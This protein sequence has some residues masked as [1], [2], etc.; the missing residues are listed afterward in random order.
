[1]ACQINGVV[2]RMNKF[3]IRLFV[4]FCGLLLSHDL[5]AQAQS[6]NKVVITDD[7][8]ILLDVTLNGVTVTRSI[9]AYQVEDK[10]LLAIEPLFD[11]LKVRYTIKNTT[12]SIWQNDKEQEFDLRSDTKAKT[13]QNYLWASDDFYFFTE[14]ALVERLFPAKMEFL[15]KGLILKIVTP[16]EVAIFPRQKI[17]QQNRQ[18]RL[19]K[20]D[21]VATNNEIIQRPIT[22]A[23]QY[24]L[25]TVPHGRVNIA[26]ETNNTATAINGSAQL[27]A[28]LLYHSA[29]LTL[30]DSDN[31]DLAARLVLSRYKTKPDDYILGVYDQ[32]QLGDVSSTTNGISTATAGGLGLNLRRQPTNFRQ[33]NQAITLEETAPPGWEAELFRNNIFLAATTVP[34][35]GLLIFDDVE[36]EFGINKYEVRLYGPF[37]ET[38]VRTK[39]V[40]LTQNSLAKGQFSHSLYGLDR[41]YRL[42]NNQSDTGYRL[43]D[44]GGTL[45]YG[46]SDNWQVGFGYAGL[47]D[48][49]QFYNLKNALSLPSLLLENDIS[50]DQ[51]GN[52]AQLTNLK[53]RAFEEDRYS[54]VFESADDFSSN[55]VSAVGKSLGLQGEYTRVT[56][57]ANLNFSLGYREDDLSKNINVGNRLS[58]NIGKVRVRHNLFYFENTFFQ[59]GQNTMNSGLQGALA[60]SGGLPYNFRISADIQYDPEAD[61]PLLKASSM[62]IQKSLRDPWQGYHSF[63]AS[64][65]PLATDSAA[66]WR[67]SHRAAWQ[68]EAFQLNVSTTYDALD[69]WSFQLGFQFFLGYD[70]HNNRLLLNHNL[71]TGSATLDVHSYLDRQLNGVPDPLDYNLSNVTF[72][73][74]PQ[75]D[76]IQS[77]KNG[78]TILPGVYATTPF[79]FGARWKKGSNTINNDYVVYTHPGA[80]VDVN[81]PFVLSTDLVGFVLRTRNGNEVGIQNVSIEL[82]DED[83]NLLQVRDTDLDG[84]YEFSGL[85]PGYYQIR[86]AATD[87][88]EK[89]YTAEVI[90]FNIL[91]GG[92]GGYSELPKIKMRRVALGMEPEAEDIVIFSLDADNTEPMVW[93][94]DANKRQNYFTLPTKD[95]VM[96]RHSLTQAA[97]NQAVVAPASSAQ[98][99]LKQD[100]TDAEPQTTMLE[101]GVSITPTKLVGTKPV[102]S[103]AL[104][105]VAKSSLLNKESTEGGL[106]ILT[107]GANPIP[108]VSNMAEQPVILASA[109]TNDADPAVTEGDYVIQLG[110]YKDK[111]EAVAEQPVILAAAVTNA[112]EPSVTEGDYV[113]QLGA[114]SDKKY[115]QELIDEMSSEMFLLESFVIIKDNAG[116]YRLTYGA[117][118]TRNSGV[119]FA[120]KYITSGQSY[121]VRKK[122]L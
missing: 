38:E 26:A 37:G 83:Q 120:N 114:Y 31:D 45:S 84:Y 68:T 15:F 51:D 92:Q 61:D 21:G 19:S 76:N 87:L 28:D 67:I 71:Q 106:P 17:E 41:N 10:L 7:Q 93:D 57:W 32:Y 77:G 43:T 62:V 30:S 59:F 48:N 85:G 79:S 49:Q 22:I 105:D 33:N 56:D 50:F 27:V 121:F 1:M 110:A 34:A 113:I 25:L 108:K 54:L 104:F 89:G 42:I 55:R 81:M 101:E 116:V 46:V 35:N 63:N 90:G 29:S 11:A 40:D 66:S 107:I 5:A 115:A 86:V 91:T 122:A 47:E 102:V 96:A 64:Y 88:E 36:V 44:Y 109:V 70:Y 8:F 94:D 2:I 58:G 95:K 75:W 20:I 97:L 16:A 4:I 9:E 117:F 14:L 52:Y 18:R 100:N 99:T 103:N 111:K 60:L 24:R 23:D 78:R 39:N 53:G 82:V 74:N 80:Y 72:S 6:L 112:A 73:G 12:I 98:V 65:L 3:H 13:P 69:K 118:L 119:E